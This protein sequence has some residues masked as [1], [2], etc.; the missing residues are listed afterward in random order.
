[1]VRNGQPEL[2]DRWGKVKEAEEMKEVTEKVK[3]TTAERR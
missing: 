1:M 2:W 3:I